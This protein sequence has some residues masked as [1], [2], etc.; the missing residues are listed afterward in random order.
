MLTL[1]LPEAVEV[2]LHRLAAATGRTKSFHV[3]EAL[4]KNL[5]EMEDVYLSERTL[6]RVR[7]GEEK[8]LASDEM[9]KLLADDR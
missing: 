6:E 9:E 7:S 8:V 4:V 1:R 3:R 2:R 5:E